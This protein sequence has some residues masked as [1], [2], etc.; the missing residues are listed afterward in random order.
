MKQNKTINNFNKLV[1]YIESKSNKGIIV[2]GTDGSG[3]TTLIRELCLH[4]NRFNVSNP[5][6]HGGLVYPF[7]GMYFDKKQRVLA[8]N[9]I[10]DRCASID[11]FVY[12]NITNDNNSPAEFDS[13][14]YSTTYKKWINELNDHFIIIIVDTPTEIVKQ[15]LMERGDKY[16][17]KVF[18]KI[19]HV[20][21]KYK[22]YFNMNMF[23]DVVWYKGATNEET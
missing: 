14:F 17:E 9:Y 6:S 1:S 13:Q 16:F 18:N 8:T 7:D 3:K 12:F 20:K 10:W 5:V 21:Q 11:S 22:E 2:L 15:R 4:F 19:E 23:N